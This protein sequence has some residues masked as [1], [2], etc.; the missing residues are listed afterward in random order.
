MRNFLIELFDNGLFLNGKNLNIFTNKVPDFLLVWQAIHN[1]LKPGLLGEFENQSLSFARTWSQ[2]IGGHYIVHHKTLG[3]L[4]RTKKRFIMKEPTVNVEPFK[5]KDSASVFVE[6]RKN[7]ITP[8]SCEFH[9]DHTLIRDLAG[10]LW[11]HNF[12]S[13]V[14]LV[15]E[16][17]N[18]F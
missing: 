15:L 3:S 4:G 2:A 18:G 16:E 12:S 9:E 6:C 17:S 11:K 5:Y 1:T 13:P 10:D 7:G 8:V 14:A